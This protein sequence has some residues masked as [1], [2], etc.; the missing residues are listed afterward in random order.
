MECNI[1]IDLKDVPRALSWLDDS[2]CVGYKDEYVLYDIST[3]KVVKHDLVVTSSSHNMDPC[4]CLIKNE[5]FG[6]TKDEH[7]ISIDPKSYTQMKKGVQKDAQIDYQRPKAPKP[8]AYS[9]AVL[10]LTWD[11]P[12]IFGRT[13]TSVEVR[14]LCGSSV[15][16]TF[17]Q[18]IPEL[19]TAK[20]LVRAAPGLLFAAAI[21]EVWYIKAVDIPTQ[22]EILLKQEK[23][24]LAIALTV[25]FLCSYIVF[26]CLSGTKL[27]IV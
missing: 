7:L 4:I 18:N 27:T 19:K 17:V 21:A 13:A 5:M 15:N 24:Q 23:F 12:Y 6:L 11:E 14:S 1:S 25:S 20:F 16:E 22:R 10:G 3:E 9:S 2:I 8:I 26:V